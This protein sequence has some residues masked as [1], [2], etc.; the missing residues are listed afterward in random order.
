MLA[1]FHAMDQHFR[2]YP[3]RQNLP[4]L[5]G[6]LAIWYTNFFDARIRRRTAL[7][8]VLEALSGLPPATDNGK[9]WQA[10]HRRGGT[11]S[12]TRQ[13]LSLGR[14]R[15]QRAAFLLPTDTSGHPIDSLRLYRI[16]PSAKPL[17]DHHD[18]LMANLFA[19][20]EALASEKPGRSRSRG[21][22]GLAGPHRVFEG[23]R[24]SNTILAERLTPDTLGTLV[25]LYEH[26]V[27]TQGAI[28]NI[29]SFDQW[30]VELGKSWQTHLAGTRG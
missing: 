1:G 12:T 29:D 28:W 13:V 4:V 25:A 22:P 20:T 16:L 3:I 18:N 24:P 6:L 5:M 21:V 30:G 15:H 23:N 10:R 19:Q 27:F 7:R 11:T 26:S 9:Q 8:A 2:T 14:T 17:G